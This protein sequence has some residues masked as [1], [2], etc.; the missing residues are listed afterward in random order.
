MGGSAADPR[1]GC[2]ANEDSLAGGVVGIADGDTLTVLDERRVQHKVW[3]ADI[4]A[5]ENGQAFV[6]ASKRNLP[7]IAFDRQV[8]VMWRKTDLY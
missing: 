6:D 4:D 3:L 2:R 8:N 7:S 5:P 1:C